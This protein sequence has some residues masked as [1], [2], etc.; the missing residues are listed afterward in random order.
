MNMKILVGMFA[1]GTTI[2]VAAATAITVDSVVQ[3]WPWNNKVDIT[4][5]VEGGQDLVSSNFCKIVFTSVINGSTY[6]IDGVNDVGASANAGTHVV[7]WTLPSGVRS[8][9]CTMS[10]AIYS[11]DVPS[12]DDYMVIDLSTGTIAYEG[13]YASQEESNARY[14]TETFKTDKLVLRKVPAGGPYPTGDTA[15]YPTGSGIHTSNTSTNW[16]TDRCYYIGV[17]SVT[18]YQ[19]ERLLSSVPSLTPG[20][21]AAQK[22]RVNV[23]WCDLRSPDGNAT[24]YFAATSSVPVVTAHQGTFLQ[25]LN[26]MTGNKFGF[27]LPTELMFEIAARAGSSTLY[28]WGS[29]VD[30]EY[31][32]CQENGNAVQPVGSRKPNS[33][34]LYD[35]AGNV[36]ELCLD[37][38]DSYVTF[39]LATS[40]SP[41][42]PRWEPRDAASVNRRCR[43]GGHYG[44]TINSG[45]AVNNFYASHNSLYIDGSNSTRKYIGFRIACIG[46]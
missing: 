29:A 10:A 14:N 11:A 8:T 18:A 39:N 31:V 37:G 15:N 40:P 42:V 24:P 6:T 16:Y 1:A 32:V 13:L 20:T 41:F 7:T 26:Y 4:Y 38:G 30:L 19:Y 33:W 34:G 43:G 25:R 22:P 21:A 12:G 46:D 5:T 9:N 27:D 35:M 2:S 3:R 28:Y 17:F 36:W 45:S 23:S 44:V